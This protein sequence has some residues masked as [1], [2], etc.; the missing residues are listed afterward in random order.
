MNSW[1]DFISTKNLNYANRKT[2]GVHSMP[3]SRNENP[4]PSLIVPLFS[5]LF[6]S[7]HLLSAAHTKKQLDDY[8]ASNPKVKIIRAKKREGLIRARLLGAKYAA[9]PVL[10]YLDSHC[11]CTVGKYRPFSTVHMNHIFYRVFN[12]RWSTIWI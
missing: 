6:L 1:R 5:S 12:V 4:T 2:D 7:I 10:T 9:A 8:F 3:C 11:E